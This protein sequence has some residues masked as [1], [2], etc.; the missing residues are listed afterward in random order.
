MSRFK[1]SN[2]SGREKGVSHDTPRIPKDRSKKHQLRKDHP[3]LTPN[4]RAELG[5]AR[6]NEREASAY[7]APS[8]PS[9]SNRWW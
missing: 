2:S 4:A 7:H 6:Q 9:Y 8:A 3:G 1:P 5:R